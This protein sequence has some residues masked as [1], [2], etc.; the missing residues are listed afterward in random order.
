[1]LKKHTRKLIYLGIAI[2]LFAFFYALKNTNYFLRTLTFVFAIIIFYSADV[3]LKLKFKKCHYLIFILISLTG[4]M[5]SPLYF[6]YPNYDKILH[7]L[8]PIL[9][10][11]L[12]FFL[13]NKVEGISFRMKLFM[14]FSIVVAMLAIF[15]VSEYLLDQFFNLKLQG[16][17]LR[18]H[19][20]FVKF[21]ILLD[22]NDDTMIDLIF[23]T[24]GALFFILVKGLTF[25]YYKFYKGKKIKRK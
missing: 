4:V 3:F 19:S 8:S 2:I 6:I 20:G 21:K 17:Y 23:G 13:V 16:V 7:V 11:V 24:V 25:S 1:M 9:L 14:T 5:F 10:S 15:E 18:D 22:R 12:V